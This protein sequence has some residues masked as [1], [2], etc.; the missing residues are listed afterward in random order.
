MDGMQHVDQAR[1]GTCVANLKELNRQLDLHRE[2]A[3]NLRR[4]SDH[5]KHKS[6][7]SQWKDVSMYVALTSYSSLFSPLVS[8]IICNTSFSRSPL[9]PYELLNTRFGETDIRSRAWSESLCDLVVFS[10]LLVC[11][12]SLGLYQHWLNQ[13]QYFIHT[14]W[15]ESA[16]TILT[17]L[18]SFINEITL[19]RAVCLI[20]CETWFF[21]LLGFFY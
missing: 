16:N 20:E 1:Y 4:F 10:T 8:L 6:Q 9:L 21:W 5:W 17:M 13:S 11:V 15:T 2:E 7:E 19:D 14:H 3:A 18:F 12:S